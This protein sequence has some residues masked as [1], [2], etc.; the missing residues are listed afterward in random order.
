MVRETRRPPP[1]SLLRLGS[2]GTLPQVS[3]PVVF[4]HTVKALLENVLAQRDLLSE[5]V[6][7]RIAALGVDVK[8]PADVDPATWWKLVQLT[9]EAL[10]PGAPLTEAMEQ[11]G[12]AV[13]AGFSATL[14]GKS[15]F[16][17]LKLL[18]PRRGLGQL[19]TQFRLADSVTTITSRVASAT[20]VEL[21][22]Q[23]RGGVPFPTYIQGMLL[24]G[25]ERVGARLAT[26]RV[27]RLGEESLQV[28]VRWEA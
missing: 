10:H 3:R 14:L 21:Q 4:S 12:R 27:T 2:S 1:R 5:Q 8:R 28:L 19:T 24:E 9:A 7:A 20:Q 13:V 11:V 25:M 23:V 6:L 15:A 17:V 26:V 22:Y 18:G 16:M